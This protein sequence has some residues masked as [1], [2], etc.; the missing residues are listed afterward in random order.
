M[1]F[2]DY[3]VSPELQRL[4]ADAKEQ[5][6]QMSDDEVEAMLRE[7]RISFAYGNLALYDPR[8]TKD[9]IRRAAKRIRLLDQ[10]PTTD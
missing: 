7:Q 3:P 6:A 10:H 8:V 2:P 5:V 4:L 9:D 1:R